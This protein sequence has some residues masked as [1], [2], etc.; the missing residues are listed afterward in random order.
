M[1][2]ILNNSPPHTNSK[3]KSTTI[4]YTNQHRYFGKPKQKACA[5]PLTKDELVHTLNQSLARTHTL[6]QQQPLIHS[7]YLALHY[8]VKAGQAHHLFKNYT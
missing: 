4:I 8:T 1:Q 5:P 6:N 3:T 2:P 7:L